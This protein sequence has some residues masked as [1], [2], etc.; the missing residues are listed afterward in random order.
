MEIELSFIVTDLSF[1]LF[2]FLSSHLL[3]SPTSSEIRTS[4]V[5]EKRK[6]FKT[7]SA[8]DTT[9]RLIIKTESNF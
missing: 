3:F 7:W 1:C 4:D 5:E 2:F 6:K 9:T 8:F